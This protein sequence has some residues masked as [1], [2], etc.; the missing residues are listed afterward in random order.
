ML[1]SILFAAIL[2]GTLTPF[3]YGQ[4]FD[5]TITVNVPSNEALD[6]GE[7]PALISKYNR[8]DKVYHQR[9]AYDALNNWNDS[10]GNRWLPSQNYR[11]R[12]YI[13]PNVAPSH[14]VEVVE[15]TEQVYVHL[16]AGENDYK[17]GNAAIDVLVNFSIFAWDADR[18]QMLGVWGG[19]LKASHLRPEQLYRTQVFNLPADLQNVAYFEIAITDFQVNILSWDGNQGIAL[20]NLKNE[21]R[22]DFDVRETTTTSGVRNSNPTD[23]LVRPNPIG[24]SQSNPQEFGEVA[25]NPV[26]LHWTHDW[27]P[28]GQNCASDSF[29]TYQL[30]I[31]RLFNRSEELYSDEDN[32]SEFI[33]EDVIDW[34]RALT[35]ETGNVHKELTLTIAEGRGWYVWR[36]RPIGDKYPGGIA[37]DLNWGVWSIA[38]TD[39]QTVT[40]SGVG[41]NNIEIN[42]TAKPPD[43]D[44]RRA[45]FFYAGIDEGKNW[46]YGRTFTEGEEGTRIAERMNYATPLL[47]TRQTQSHLGSDNSSVLAETIYDF[48][49]RGAVTT[50][51]APVANTVS[52]NVWSGFAYRADFVNYSPAQFDDD[53]NHTSPAAMTGILADYYDAGNTAEPF[54]A[55][56]D[57]YPFTRALYYPDADGRVREQGGVGRVHRIG[58][59]DDESGTTRHTTLTLFGPASDT[60]LLALFGDEAPKA[61]SVRAIYTVDPNKVTSIQYVGK[62]GKPLATFLGKAS[63]NAYLDVNLGAEEAAL[64]NQKVT[65]DV[66][67]RSFDREGITYTSRLVIEQASTD[68]DLTY[69][70][71]P[72]TL[73]PCIIGCLTCDYILD[74]TIG[75]ADD[76][77]LPSHYTYSKNL[78]GEDLCSNHGTVITLSTDPALASDPSKV[79]TP[80][81]PPFSQ[82]GTYIVTLRLRTNNLAGGDPYGRR[83]RE[84]K[85]AEIR[86]ALLAQMKTDVLD[87]IRSY[88]EAGNIDQLYEALDLPQGPFSSH[89]VQSLA[90]DEYG[91]GGYGLAHDLAGVNCWELKIPKLACEPAECPM[92]FEFEEMLYD[93]WGTTALGWGTDPQKYFYNSSGKTYPQTDPPGDDI[94]AWGIGAFNKMI[95]HMVNDGYD[96]DEL[97][98]VWRP[99]A[100]NF[101]YMAVRN[102]N[103]VYVPDSLNTEF[104]LLETFLRGVGRKFRGTSSCAYGDCGDN[105]LGYLE[106]AYRFFDKNLIGANDKCLEVLEDQYTDTSN[107]GQ[108]VKDSELT[109]LEKSQAVNQKK[110]WEQLYLCLKSKGRTIPAVDMG[111]FCVPDENGNY[112][113]ECVYAM[114]DTAESRCRSVCRMREEAFRRKLIEMYHGLSKKIEGEAILPDGTDIQSWPTISLKELECAVEALVANCEGDCELTVDESTAGEDDDGPDEGET[115]IV[116]IGIGEQKEKILAVYLYDFKVKLATPTLPTGAFACSASDSCDPNDPNYPIAPWPTEEEELPCFDP[117]VVPVYESTFERQGRIVERLMN[118]KLREYAAADDGTSTPAQHCAFLRDDIVE[119]VLGYES[120]DFC[121]EPANW[122]VPLSSSTEEACCPDEHPWSDL[123]TFREGITG[124]FIVRDCDLYYRRICTRDG[125]DYVTEQFLCADVCDVTCSGGFCFQ[126]VPPAEPDLEDAIVIR[127]EE[128][129]CQSML[130]KQ[131][132]AE[133]DRQVS[134]L[135]DE[136]VAAFLASYDRKCLTPFNE[137]AQIA[138][139]FTITKTVNYYH[140]TLYYY[141]RAGNLVRTVPPAGVRLLPPEERNREVER[142]EHKMVTRYR[143]NSLGQMVWKSTPDGGAT[144]YWYD[145]AGRLR[146]SQDANQANAFRF[147]DTKMRVSYTKYDR[148]SRVVEVGQCEAPLYMVP[149]LSLTSTYPNTGGEQ[150]VYT[151]Y[152]RRHEP[153]LNPITNN[154]QYIDF[155]F[156]R[157][158]LNRVA[159]TMAEVPSMPPTTMSSEWVHT[160]YSYDPHGNVEWIRQELPALENT[161]THFTRYEYDLISGNV[162]ALYYNEGWTDQMYHRYRY[163][164]DNRLLE[165]KTSRDREIWE[166]D[167]RYYYYPHGPLRRIEYGEDSVQGIDYVYTIHGWTKGINHTALKHDPARQFDPGKDGQTFPAP[168]SGFARDV[169]GMTLRYYLNDY[170]RTAYPLTNWEIVPQYNL[171]NGNISSWTG[172]IQSVGG[173]NMFEDLTGYK[174]RYDVLNRLLSA[175]FMFRSGAG[176]LQSPTPPNL[177]KETFAYD[178]NGNI[179]TLFRGGSQAANPIMDNLQ[180]TYDTDRNRLLQV[181]DLSPAPANAYTNDIES[182]A[183]PTRDRYVYD[184]IGNLVIDRSLVAAA[185]PPNVIGDTLTWSVYG[186]VLSVKKKSGIEIHFAYDAAG[187]RV[188]KMV[189]NL[190]NINLP[191]VTTYYVYEANSRVM[192]IYETDC[193]EPP[194]RGSGMGEPDQTPKPNDPDGDTWLNGEDN[195]PNTFNPDQRDF[196]GDGIGDACDN[197]PCIPNTNQADGDFDN[198]GDMCEGQ[199]EDPFDPDGDGGGLD[200]NCVCDYNPGQ[201]DV[202]QDGY[203]DACD[204]D[205]G[206]CGVLFP[207]WYI[208]G[209]SAEGR[210]AVIK[211]ENPEPRNPGWGQPHPIPDMIVAA[212]FTRVLGEK[213]YELKD[214]L[215]NVRAIV[216]DIKLNG[217]PD[218]GTPPAQSGA[219]PYK[220]DLRAYNNY[221]AFGSLHPDR[222]W[223]TNESRYGFNG[224]EM[225]N[226]MHNEQ[227]PPPGTDG[228]GNFY[229]YGFRVY[230]PR[231]ARFLSVDPLAPEYPWYTPYQFAGNNPIEFIDVDGLEPAEPGYNGQGARAPVKDAEDQSNVN[232]IYSTS[233]GTWAQTSSPM[234]TG[235]DLQELFPNGNSSNLRTLETTINLHGSQ[236]GIKSTDHLAHYLGQ[237]GVETD[238]F[239]KNAEI[240]NGKFRKARVAALWGKKSY[241][242]NR[243]TQDPSLLTNLEAFYNAAY[244]SENKPDL[245]NGNEASGDGYKY[246]GRGFFQLTGKGNYTE[247]T[248]FYQKVYGSTNS[249]VSNPDKVAT[250]QDIA[251]ISSLWYYKKYTISAINK[252]KDFETITKTVN[253]GADKLS[254][255]EKVYN[256]SLEVLN[257]NK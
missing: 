116:G 103:G 30:Q 33:I 187:N 165:V 101:G 192:A 59:D 241:I 150:R 217:S 170:Q 45:F 32:R 162:R 139:A 236:F 245:G 2:A 31:L 143:Y 204:E 46:I 202:D 248:I 61:E 240:S 191:V 84:K 138:D 230:D 1:C 153:P 223:N 148:L 157:Y 211:P 146:F 242:Y 12:L 235:S 164:E 141:D 193:V 137:D 184:D 24:R 239:T 209:N 21:I 167:A 18:T 72:D 160:Q 65:Y 126:W 25:A 232:W 127:L 80:S 76:P 176:T 6:N 27:T 198:I 125:V 106:Y 246:R 39:D 214:H 208:Y 256:R 35:I 224:K 221:Y 255:R 117:A 94:G 43:D 74:V 108:D 128:E 23:V 244:G 185:D 219:Y 159:H 29:P 62:E 69:S 42:G 220:A 226:E 203:G 152:T 19:T 197:C 200:D 5:D 88:L 44:V 47:R 247:F 119:A 48:S 92:N 105:T 188:R 16:M 96:L 57:G 22:L 77:S 15:K 93:R 194:T 227:T 180:Y 107:W 234:V 4:K 71:S 13:R 253:S 66:T 38:P 169:F 228:T 175:S 111:E 252:G 249:F 205:G 133:I 73:A 207:E 11:H 85:A 56:A 49:G 199:Y 177:Y 54:V 83:M 17:F 51:A 254:E 121:A 64:N 182:P 34:S 257:R 166:S 118:R 238:G 155:T 250:D 168:H 78:T 91:Q 131:L 40:I 186:K 130:S 178:P 70:F 9:Y 82:V 63:S 100:E 115:D 41:A 36:V 113:P 20:T 154:G 149:Y 135:V 174:Y 102:T 201:T 37:N 229:D 81:V 231:I 206:E 196:D 67:N 50:L 216:S 142:P 104:D 171:Y 60:V 134:E 218:P 195:C 144:A 55:S 172:H 158:T 233:K 151:F 97:C 8:T 10:V 99:L 52:A 251:I 90:P 161:Y 58:G 3:A 122:D 173:G 156:Q 163:D 86:D 243:I 129:S 123:F 26:R 28:T 132:L 215:G 53:G 75:S 140:F 87:D 183:D 225:V 109:D 114:R 112:T 120:C 98:N 222:R 110:S 95:E 212:T 145:I 147:A 89:Y 68:V 14:C 136:Q 190:P 181:M 79:M 179:K 189:R 213:E 237:A 7:F 124:E 210:I